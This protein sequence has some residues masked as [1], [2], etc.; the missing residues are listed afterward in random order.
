MAYAKI[1][2]PQAMAAAFVG[3]RDVSGKTLREA[4][5][6]IFDN[7]LPSTIKV[8]ARY[9]GIE[10]QAAARWEHIRSGT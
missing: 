10:R 4:L 9:M 1:L 3:I 6:G 2:D 5:G 7:A 8:C